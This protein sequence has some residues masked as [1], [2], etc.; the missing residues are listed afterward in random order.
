MGVYHWWVSD[1]IAYPTLVDSI[2]A[3]DPKWFEIHIYNGSFRNAIGLG[4]DAYVGIADNVMKMNRGG[5]WF[6]ITAPTYSVQVEKVVTMNPTSFSTISGGTTESFP[7]TWSTVPSP[8]NN[9]QGAS[10]TITSLATIGGRTSTTRIP[11][12][13]TINRGTSNSRAEQGIVRLGCMFAAIF[14]GV[15]AIL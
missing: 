13:A 11:T 9:G 12:F 2:Y 6:N 15:A 14:V 4:E 10:S 8:P 7:V 3:G 5:M 1:Q